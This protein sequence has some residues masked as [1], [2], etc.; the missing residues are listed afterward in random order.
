MPTGLDRTDV[1]ATVSSSSKSY[2]ENHKLIIKKKK[3]QGKTQMDLSCWPWSYS[4]PLIG[5]I[6]LLTYTV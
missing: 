2:I 6:H 1:D 3:E 5:D 4:Q